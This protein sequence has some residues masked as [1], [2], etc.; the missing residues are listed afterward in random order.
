MF[1]EINWNYVIIK[2]EGLWDMMTEL[3]SVHRKV[4]ETGNWFPSSFHKVFP[5]SVSTL[6]KSPY[7]G[8]CWTQIG[9]DIQGHGNWPVLH[10]ELESYA[11]D[12]LSG[13]P[14][15]LANLSVLTMTN[16]SNRDTMRKSY[17]LGKNPPKRAWNLFWKQTRF[18][19]T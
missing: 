10:Q 9:V 7:N 18:I 14:M 3:R 6:S 5:R 1:I 2:W 11:N 4:E 16:A 12:Y 8:I 15:I 19:I 17:F 13:T